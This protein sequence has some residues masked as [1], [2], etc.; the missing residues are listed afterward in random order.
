[1]E[2]NNIKYESI[3]MRRIHLFFFIVASLIV[4][5]PCLS[6]AQVKPADNMRILLKKLRADKKLVVAETMQL[7]QS[8][9]KDFWPLYKRYQK[10]LIT[11]MTR[12]R[13]IIEKYA[14]I[15]NFMTN[16]LAKEM[17]D[18]W[19]S[20]QADWLKIQRDYLPEFRKSMP[21]V[22]VMRYY[23]LES[24]IDSVVRYELS[25]IIPLAHK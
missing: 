17:V 3:L 19:L 22:K 6:S 15:H 25:S 16:K 20:V 12:M 2:S 23:Q 13:E 14:K 24:K 1:M 9:A 11:Q 18:E 4:T 10:D 8:E 21:D 7:T 5:S